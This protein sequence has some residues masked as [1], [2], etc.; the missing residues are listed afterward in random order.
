MFFFHFYSNAS[1]AQDNNVENMLQ[2]RPW[3]LVLYFLPLYLKKIET[4]T[5]LLYAKLCMGSLKSKSCISYCI[6]CF[7]GKLIKWRNIVSIKNYLVNIIDT[8]SIITSPNLQ[9]DHHFQP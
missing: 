6:L 4:L 2:T 8:K 7:R 3:T 5:S 1:A 9:Y